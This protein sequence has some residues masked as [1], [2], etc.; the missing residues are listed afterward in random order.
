MITGL[1]TVVGSLA[2]LSF[3]IARR[4]AFAKSAFQT[5]DNKGA[6]R[7]VADDLK[8]RILRAVAEPDG[9]EVQAPGFD[10]P[11]I[12]LQPI[13]TLYRSLGNKQRL[14]ELRHCD[15]ELHLFSKIDPWRRA[16]TLDEDASFLRNA[17][18]FQA[19]A[20]HRSR[21]RILRA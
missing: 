14:I 13:I 10:R 16:I 9:A 11:D 17:V 15:P 7:Q 3:R 1:P 19:D 2:G 8:P 5:C 21:E 4:T 20:D 18:A 12:S 6:F